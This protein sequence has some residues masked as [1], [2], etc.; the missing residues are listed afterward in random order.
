LA[1]LVSLPPIKLAHHLLLLETHFRIYQ[2]EIKKCCY[3]NL[4]IQIFLLIPGET[5]KNGWI[6]D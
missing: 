6:F 2:P 1:T 4:F 3:P 5:L